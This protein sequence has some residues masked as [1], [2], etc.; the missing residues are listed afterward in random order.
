MK[1]NIY[2]A[3]ITGEGGYNDRGQLGKKGLSYLQSTSI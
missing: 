2:T 3:I 1:Y